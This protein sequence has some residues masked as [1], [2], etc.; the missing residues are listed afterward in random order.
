MITFYYG[1]AERNDPDELDAFLD[2]AYSPNK[3]K[4]PKL[5]DAEDMDYFILQ[6][7]ADSMFQNN[8][9]SKNEPW[10]DFDEDKL[11]ALLRNKFFKEYNKKSFT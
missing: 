5:I 8:S 4:Y 1:V 9:Q 3:D 11:K 6:S 2:N 7:I 10:M